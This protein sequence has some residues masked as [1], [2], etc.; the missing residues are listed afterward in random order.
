M[1]KLIFATLLT[2]LMSTS[3]VMAADTTITMLWVKDTTTI[4]YLA[5]GKTCGIGTNNGMTA[6]YAK[7]FLATALTAKSSG[8]TVNVNITGANCKNIFLK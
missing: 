1:K 6:D 4:M 8:A 7:N 3:N 2:G 5:N